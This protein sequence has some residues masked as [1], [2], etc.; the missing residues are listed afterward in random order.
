PCLPPRPVSLIEFHGTAD[1]TVPYNGDQKVHESPVF[2]WAT[3]WAEKDGCEDKP[4]IDTHNNVIS[5]TWPQCQQ[6]AAIIQYKILGGRHQW[7]AFNFSLDLKGKEEE[8][9]T[10]SL[11]W[12]FFYN[13]PLNS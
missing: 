7:P 4:K 9:S 10:T 8:M 3:S 6:H 1:H 12:D 11:I 5:Y 13:H 2:T